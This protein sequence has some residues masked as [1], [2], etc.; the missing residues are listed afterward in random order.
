MKTNNFSVFGI[1]AGGVFTLFAGLR[2]F[3]IWPD[4]DRALAYV[5]MGL[6]IIAI[7]WLYD[8][9]RRTNNTLLAVENYLADRPWDYNK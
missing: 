3:V 5:T 7:S 1:L 2:Y 6:V 4:L 9:Q 8:Q